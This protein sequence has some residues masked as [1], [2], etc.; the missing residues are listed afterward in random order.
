M[1]EDPAY[2]EK[3]DEFFEEYGDEIEE[4]GDIFNNYDLEIETESEEE[5]IGGEDDGGSTTDNPL[6]SEVASPSLDFSSCFDMGE[7]SAVDMEEVTL[8]SVPEDRALESNQTKPN[9]NIPPPP[10]PLNIPKPLKPNAKNTGGEGERRGSLLDQIRSGTSLRK[11]SINTTQKRTTQ[12]TH[13]ADSIE[14][15]LLGAMQQIRTMKDTDY[16]ALDD[17]TYRDWDASD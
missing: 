6:S 17:A 8:E 7:Y 1:L 15:V 2:C 5:I 13:V 3:I 10:P 14:N 4:Y 16:G 12:R 9:T 11:S